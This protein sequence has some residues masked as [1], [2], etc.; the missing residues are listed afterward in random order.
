LEPKFGE[1]VNKMGEYRYVT[2]GTPGFLLVESEDPEDC[3][4]KEDQALYHSVVGTLQQF[5]NKSCP[6]V[7][8]TVSEL[9]K[10]MNKAPPVA[11]LIELYH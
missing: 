5:L 4:S 6:D 3:L 9:S 10:G 1:A 11:G 8:N 2:P 7:S